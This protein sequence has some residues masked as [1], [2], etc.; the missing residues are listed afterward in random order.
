MKKR[1]ILKNI[2][3]EKGRKIKQREIKK[4]TSQ[5]LERLNKLKVGCQSIG[6]YT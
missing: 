4:V 1:E 3:G 2:Y 5:S 6:K